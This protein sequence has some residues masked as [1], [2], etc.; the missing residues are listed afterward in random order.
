MSRN[1]IITSPLSR[2][3]A[4]VTAMLESYPRVTVCVDRDGDLIVGGANSERMTAYV[5]RHPKD[6][7][8][9][10][11]RLGIKV[12]YLFYPRSGPDTESWAKAEQVWCASDRNDAFTRLKRGEMI[13]NEDSYCEL[14]PET[15]LIRVLTTTTVA[16]IDSAANSPNLI[17]D[18]FTLIRPPPS[19]REI[20]APPRECPKLYR[21][22]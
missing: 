12:R 10:Y 7:I 20:P 3:V 1:N 8:A 6:K 19:C 9:D 5:A 21:P 18:F 15:G 13:P 4:E 22:G 11:N 16:R 14:D 17:R 2:C